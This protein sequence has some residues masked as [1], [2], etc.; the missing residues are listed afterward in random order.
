VF[1]IFCSQVNARLLNRVGASGLLS[2]A[3]RVYL[4]A[5]SVLVVDAWAG[6]GGLLG[7]L[8]PITFTMASMGFLSPNAIVGAMSRQAGH[9]GSASALMG[10]MQF[11]FGA[12]SGFV[13]GLITDGTARP[14]AGLIMVGAVCANI[15]DRMRPRL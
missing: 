15:A 1:F 9:A 5:A 4:V 2:F 8:L 12:V 3:C 7:I 14:M 6:W 13:V 10:T 11:G